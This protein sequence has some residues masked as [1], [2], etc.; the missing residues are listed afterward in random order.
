MPYQ[1][2]MLS[3]DVAKAASKGDVERVRQY[4]ELYPHH[5]NAPSVFQSTLLHIAS[6][7]GQPDVVQLLIELGADTASL[8]YGT[9][10]TVKSFRQVDCLVV[11]NTGSPLYRR[12]ASDC[13]PV[14]VFVRRSADRRAADRC[15]SRSKGKHRRGPDS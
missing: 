10:Q 14:G 5:I 13:A 15:G 9:R 11:C 12:N 7:A 6:K 3:H 2:N 8:D 4:L 1:R